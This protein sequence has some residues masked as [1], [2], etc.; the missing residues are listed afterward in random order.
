MQCSFFPP[1]FFPVPLSKS[2]RPRARS[3]SVNSG[4]SRVRVASD[5]SLKSRQQR[6]LAS[7]QLE[8]RQ[9]SFAPSSLQSHRRALLTIRRESMRRLAMTFHRQ[10]GGYQCR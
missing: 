7:L 1:A 3:T 10:R 8:L 9:Q 6:L 4:A 5:S 2:A